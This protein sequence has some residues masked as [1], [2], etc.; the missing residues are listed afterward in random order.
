MAF[1]DLDTRT[2]YDLIRAGVRAGITKVSDIER[3]FDEG[4][5][6]YGDGTTKLGFAFGDGFQQSTGMTPEEIKEL[7]HQVAE[8]QRQ[9]EKTIGEKLLYSKAADVTAKVLA[10]TPVGKRAIETVLRTSPDPDG[11][12][13][14]IQGLKQISDDKD[15]KRAAAIT[16]YIFGGIKAGRKGYYNSLAANPDDYYSGFINDGYENGERINGNDIFDASLHN[17]PIDSRFGLEFQSK[18][19]PKDL[20]PRITNYIKKAYGNKIYNVPLYTVRNSYYGDV[21]FRQ[22][23]KLGIEPI[24]NNQGLEKDKSIGE[25][26]KEPFETELG[27]TVDVGNHQMIKGTDKNGNVYNQHYD[28][29]DFLGKDYNNVWGDNWKNKSDNYKRLIELGLKAINSAETPI[30]VKSNWIKEENE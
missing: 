13:N 8:S 7:S 4:G 17:K 21:D 27:P 15:Y 5:H 16:A 26:Y 19:I 25:Y 18:G 1:K 2:R 3:L 30:V 6:L 14:T 29:F 23:K 11:L 22:G 28:I 12:D 24:L 9:Q 20:G 10:K